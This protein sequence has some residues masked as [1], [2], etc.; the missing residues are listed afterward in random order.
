MLAKHPY[1]A[2][3]PQRWRSLGIHGNAD[4]K[5]RAAQS[6]YEAKTFV[7]QKETRQTNIG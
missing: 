1:A 6:V 2:L 4:K 3:S 7:I 5:K